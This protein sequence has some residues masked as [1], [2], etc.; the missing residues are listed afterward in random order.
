MPIY[1]RD[2]FSS[3]VFLLY[4]FVAPNEDIQQIVAG[5][6]EHGTPPP[7][8]AAIVQ[9]AVDTVGS[10]RKAV[11]VGYYAG[12]STTFHTRGSLPPEK[13]KGLQVTYIAW[14]RNRARPMLIAITRYQKDGNP[15]ASGIDEVAPNGL[16]RGYA[17]P[18][19]LFGVSSFFSARGNWAFLPLC[20]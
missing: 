17:L 14:F 13:V 18:G 19:L 6:E 11:K 16:V 12:A 7:E 1:V 5:L 8:S 9:Q 4:S 15:A 3:S 2:I 10:L 20:S